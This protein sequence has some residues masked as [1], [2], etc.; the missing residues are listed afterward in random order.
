MSFY[1][2]TIERSMVCLKQD[3]NQPIRFIYDLS[4]QFK[5][6][7]TSIDHVAKPFLIFPFKSH[8]NTVFTK[9]FKSILRYAIPI[10]KFDEEKEKGL[11]EVDLLIRK[12]P[13]HS[14][15]PLRKDDSK[16][17]STIA[18]RYFLAENDSTIK[19]PPVSVQLLVTNQCTTKCKM[20]DHFKLFKPKDELTK[21]E[22][23]YTLE[24]IKAIGTTNVIISGGEPLARPDIFEI[25]KYG[26]NINLNIGLLTN[27]VKKDGNSLNISEAKVISEMCSWVQ[28]SIDS[29]NR[30]TY[31]LI[32]GDNYLEIVLESLNNIVKAGFKDI[33]VCFTI[34]KDNVDEINS[35]SFPESVNKLL[36]PSIPVRFKFAHG[37]SVDRDFLCP[38]D[39]LVGVVQEFQIR[40]PRFNFEYL[41]SMIESGY[42]DYEGLSQGNPLKKRMIQ[43]EAKGYKCHALRLTCK[44]DSNGDV[45]PCCF[46]FDDNCA[47]SKL[48]N[49]YRLGSLRSQN[50]HRVMPPS[51]HENVLAN[52]WYKSEKLRGYRNVVLPVDT[53]ACNYCTRHFYQNEFLNE[54]NDVFN[55]YRR[56]G[57]VEKQIN[58]GKNNSTYAFWV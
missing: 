43:Y 45:Y 4:I 39:K 29:F 23:F 17:L 49:N 12:Y 21:D 40:N 52:I 31:R 18:A 10:K 14:H 34:Q 44:I 58:D 37:P 9:E 11:K 38:K 6:P 32:R 3:S 41:S 35:N 48:R 54:L 27:G 13:R 2:K 53:E 15:S 55:R 5:E 46:L 33:E 51:L 57:I 25:L 7:E 28:L 16:F 22:V 26:K 24:C 30:D 8:E 50:T 1:N 47:D 42:F 36:P 56:Y 20:C 19:V